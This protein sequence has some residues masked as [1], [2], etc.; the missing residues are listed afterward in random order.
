[1]S[2]HN[3]SKSSDKAP[4]SHWRVLAHEATQTVA[5]EDRGIFDELVVDDW[6]HLEQ[7]S[8]REWCLRVGDA[9]IWISVEGDVPPR[10]DIQR[11]FYNQVRGDTKTL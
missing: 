5:F 6:L 8:K 3:E 10:V 9:R 2:S 11:G 4:G 1:M 7:M